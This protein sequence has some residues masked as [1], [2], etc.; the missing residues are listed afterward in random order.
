[1]RGIEGKHMLKSR[2]MLKGLLPRRML[3]Q[4]LRHWLLVSALRSTERWSIKTALAYAA[5]FR[6]MHASALPA[7]SMASL[8]EAALYMPTLVRLAPFINNCS[9][10]VLAE[11]R[12]MY[13]YYLSNLKVYKKITWGFDCA[14]GLAQ[15]TVDKFHPCV[16]KCVGFLHSNMHELVR[17][18]Q[19]I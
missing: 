8:V 18:L 1:M 17:S 2:R 3:Q 9:H 19:Y 11:P 14:C 13:L 10:I 15:T 16:G 6:P 12:S 7:A 4:T 5:I